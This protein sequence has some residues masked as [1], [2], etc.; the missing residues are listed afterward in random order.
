MCHGVSRGT[1]A[2]RE[3][4]QFIHMYFVKCIDVAAEGCKYLC[5]VSGCGRVAACMWKSERPSVTAQSG[6]E[7]VELNL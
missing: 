2:H 3:C 4:H 1:W 7:P 5:P 6:V